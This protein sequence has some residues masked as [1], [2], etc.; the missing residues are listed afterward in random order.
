M[1]DPKPYSRVQSSARMRSW[2]RERRTM[3][4][5]G[6]AALVAVIVLNA[7]VLSLTL[8]ESI[9]WTIVGAMIG[10]AIVGVC[11][12]MHL[13]FVIHDR[14]AVYEIRGAWGEDF[15]RDVLRRALRR[16][17]VWGVVNGLVTQSGDIDHIVVSRRGGLVVIDSKFYTALTSAQREALIEAG[18]GHRRSMKGLARTVVPRGYG[19]H[20][21]QEH[22]PVTTAIVLWGPARHDVPEPQVVDGVHLMS[23]DDLYAW[24]K[25]LTGEPIPKSFGRE[26]T[27]ELRDWAERQRERTAAKANAPAG[28]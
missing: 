27:A 19:R 7:F 6:V 9:R 14:A 13:S 12:V 21:G 3:L 11:W 10:A 28:S 20:R 25:T 18:R 5:Q 15:T 23:G 1:G 26:L 4:V 8:P 17:Q 2:L 24:L 22:I 16:R